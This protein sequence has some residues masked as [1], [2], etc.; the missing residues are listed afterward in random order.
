MEKRPSAEEKPS[1]ILAA[2]L[3]LFAERGFAATNV[4]LIAERAG[5]SVGTLYHYFTSKE[6]MAN[7]LYRRLRR[8]M[9][10]AV[11]RD[12]PVGV[13]PA[14]QFR[15]MWQRAVAFGM[16]KPLAFAF[17]ETHHHR[18]YLDAASLALD[19]QVVAEAHQTVERG[20]WAGVLKPVHDEV[21][22]AFVDG[23]IKH[24]VRSGQEGRLKLTPE[25]VDQAA[26]CCWQAIKEGWPSMDTCTLAGETGRISLSFEY[27]GDGDCRG[28]ASIASGGCQAQGKVWFSV[29]DV[30]AFHGRLESCYRAL[31]GAAAFTTHEDH[32]KLEVVFGPRG[33]VAIQGTFREAHNVGNVLQFRIPTDQSFVGQTLEELATLVGRHGG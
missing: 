22:A 8:E 30:A 23:A 10:K 1:A 21:L 7:E 18:P 24:L 19:R 15:V 4:P 32:L 9:Y 17:L 28:T 20:R 3:E 5:V 29:A 27:V 12:L 13:P 11:H 31:D 26:A 6:A 25:V 33:Q 2:A 14:E 16:A